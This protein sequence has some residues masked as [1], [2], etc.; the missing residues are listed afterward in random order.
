V[1]D[2]ADVLERL[3]RRDQ[4]GEVRFDGFTLDRLDHA[5]LAGRFGAVKH[6]KADS[7]AQELG[8]RHALEC[9]RNV[10]GRT[11]GDPSLPGE[12]DFTLPAR[13]VEGECE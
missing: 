5:G 12:I 7:V 8:S 6:A 4:Q 2:R 3:V 9:E 1:R 11:A 13:H 10:P